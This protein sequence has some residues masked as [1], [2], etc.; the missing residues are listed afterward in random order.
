MQSHSSAAALNE[1]GTL[2]CVGDDR[3]IDDRHYD[4]LAVVI[5]KVIDSRFGGVQRQAERELGISQSHI[6]QILRG[7]KADRKCGLATLIKLREATGIPLDELLGLD[8]LGV[9][10]NLE[11][12]IA[13]LESR[14][15]S[16][17]QDSIPPPAAPARH[18]AAKRPR[19][20]S[21]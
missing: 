4:H 2:T 8:P 13:R 12:R 17:E 6:S 7:S 21:A 10:A 1:A 9:E 14:L 3:R 11:E 18:A 20:K 19:S 5:R 15:A 16:M